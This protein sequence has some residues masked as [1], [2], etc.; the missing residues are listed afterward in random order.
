MG[1]TGKTNDFTLLIGKHAILF[2]CKTSALFFSAKKHASLEE[3]R[4]DLKKNLVNP[5]AKKGLFQ[6]HEKIEAIKSKKLPPELNR[7]YEAVERFYPVVLLY[8]Q[9]LF[10]NKPE[11]LRNVLDSELRSSGIADFRY[12]V[13]HM[14]KLENLFELVTAK[15]GLVYCPIN[16]WQ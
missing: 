13:W 16:K 4:Q 3:V 7:R 9:I 12:Q 8:D 11:T 1:W 6:L 10:A 14:E 5:E 2:E 15:D